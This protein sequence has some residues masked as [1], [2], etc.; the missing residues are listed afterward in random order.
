MLSMRV[1]G[2]GS[3]LLLFSGSTEAIPTAPRW[4]EGLLEPEQIKHS[5]VVKSWGFWS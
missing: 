4:S 3:A 1:A 5:V 2:T